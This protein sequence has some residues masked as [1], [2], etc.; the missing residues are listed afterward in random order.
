[1]FCSKCGNEIAENSRFCTSCGAQA[2]I[3]TGGAPRGFDTSV[4]TRDQG[5]MQSGSSDLIY[6]KNP[7]LSPHLCWLNLVIGG[8]AQMIYGQAAKGC[9]ILIAAIASNFV[10]PLLLAAAIGVASIVDAYRVGKKLAAG[11]AV[12][13]WEW[14]PTI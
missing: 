12:G 11:E 4:G 2:Q 1:M 5:R 7:P 6:P 3:S 9:V 10:L 8:L 14:F 13:K